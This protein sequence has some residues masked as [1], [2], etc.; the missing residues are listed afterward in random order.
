MIDWSTAFALAPKIAVRRLGEEQGAVVVRLG[1]GQ[2]F[3]CNDTTAAFL[4]ALDGRRSFELVLEQ[5]LA[6]FDVERDRLAED[7][8][9]LAEQLLTEGLIRAVPVDGAAS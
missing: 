4:E 7:L 5:L 8:G 9:A 1:D 6:G 3:T 2:L